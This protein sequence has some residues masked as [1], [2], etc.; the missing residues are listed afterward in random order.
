MSLSA[1]RLIADVTDPE[2]NGLLDSFFSERQAAR[3]IYFRGD[4]NRVEF[5]PVKPADGSAS[6]Y[7][8]PETISSNHLFLGIG[9]ADLPADGG[10]ISGLAYNSD[11]T[12]LTALAYNISAAN[13]ETAIN[14]NPA[15]SSIPDTVSVSL[16]AEGVYQVSFESVGSRSLFTA[17]PTGLIPECNIF[18]S[19]L[20]TG[21]ATEKEIQIIQIIQRPYVYVTDWTATDSATATVTEIR[22]GSVSAKAMFEVEISPLPYAGSFYV[23]DSGAMAYNGQQSDWASALG[24][25]WS[26]IKTGDARFTIERSEVGAYELSSSDIDVSGLSVF[27]GLRGQLKFNAG[28]LF[29]RFISEASG[30]FSTT[31]EI[32]HD[33]GTDRSVLVHDTVVLS[34]EILSSGALAPSDW[35]GGFYRKTEIDAFLSSL[36]KHNAAVTVSTTGTTT[37]SKSASTEKHSLYLISAGAGSGAYTRKIVLS[38]TNCAAG[39][40]AKIRVDFTASSNPSIEIRN[41]SDAGDLLF[42]A[43]TGDGTAFAWVAEAYF[44]GAAWKPLKNS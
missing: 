22:T 29:K 24:S 19:R 44:D 39:D 37:L 40:V 11:S 12:G 33:D 28:T 23:G 2:K 5:Y 38:T 42:T 18:V 17:D 36:F 31:L 32:T 14:A 25:G 10:E 16:L 4:K 41:A 27:S 34:K 6:M 1:V 20:Q 15:I 9:D 7:W 35:N 13:L 30:E 43:M 26:A 8:L 3:G 21:S